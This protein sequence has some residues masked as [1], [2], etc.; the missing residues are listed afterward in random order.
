MEKT[1][2][3]DSPTAAIVKKITV[4]RGSY[5][6]TNIFRN[7]HELIQGHTWNNEHKVVS[8]VS[9]NRDADGHADSYD[10]DIVTKA[11]CG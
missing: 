1:F 6:E 4:A 8:V 7:P 5:R 9:T 10:V 2:S 3:P 11:I